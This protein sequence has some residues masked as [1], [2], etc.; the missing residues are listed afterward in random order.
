MSKGTFRHP[1]GMKLSELEVPHG[2]TSFVAILRAHDRFGFAGNI[3]IAYFG[4]IE[5]GIFY[6][7]SY[8]YSLAGFNQD[9]RDAYN[10]HPEHTA[11]MGLKI[12]GTPSRTEK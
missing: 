10:T 7:T 1:V 6:V 11:M 3:P 5:D 2:G 4:Y 9:V 8:S 12:A